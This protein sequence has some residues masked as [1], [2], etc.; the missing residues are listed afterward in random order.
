MNI[1]WLQIQIF[2]AR[3]ERRIAGWS[4]KL[5]IPRTGILTNVATENPIIK[6]RDEFGRNGAVAVLDSE[7]RNTFVRIDDVWLD[8]CIRRTGV[9]AGA[10]AP[11][12]IGLR[13][14]VFELEIRYYLS[15]EYPRPDLPAG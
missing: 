11:A 5:P 4:R 8:D 13:Q 15:E 7:K 2:P 10:A 12:V 3:K 1:L 9:D 6:V 14:I